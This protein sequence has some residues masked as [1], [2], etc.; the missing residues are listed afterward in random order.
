MR[1]RLRSYSKEIGVFQIPDLAQRTTCKLLAV[2]PDDLRC[3][4]LKAIHVN[5]FPGEAK[6]WNESVGCRELGTVAVEKR[7]RGLPG[8]LHDKQVRPQHA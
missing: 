4:M 8:K 7:K 5:S 2:K 1:S 6:V 3:Y